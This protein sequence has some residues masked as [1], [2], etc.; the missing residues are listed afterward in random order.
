M[1]FVIQENSS[2]LDLCK[3]RKKNQ[4]DGILLKKGTIFIAFYSKIFDM[5]QKIYNYVF[6]I[7]AKQIVI[8]HK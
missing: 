6:L 4:T 3:S 2:D 7:Q 5:L 8:H 1:I